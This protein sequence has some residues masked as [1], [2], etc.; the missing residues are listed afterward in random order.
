M[1][2]HENPVRQHQSEPQRHTPE[3]PMRDELTAAEKSLLRRLTEVLR[4]ADF[5]ALL[6][7]AATAFSAYATWRTATIA[8]ELLTSSERPYF[9]VEGVNLDRSVVGDP[10]VFVEYRNFGHVPAD[11]VNLQAMMFIDDQPLD[12]NTVA[13]NVGI[14]SPNVPH[15]I[16]FHIPRD[17]FALVAEGHTTLSTQIHAWYKSASG[18]VFCYRER[19]IYMRDSGIFEIGGGS[20]RCDSLPPGT[21]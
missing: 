18:R 2:E 5:M 8:Q 14:L 4:F 11:E 17:R 9:G 20:S 21:S 13:K 3:P 12:S 6:M 16:Y 1:S 15:H 7:V 10:R 19:F